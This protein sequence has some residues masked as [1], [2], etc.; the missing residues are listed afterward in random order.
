MVYRSSQFRSLEVPHL[1]E[2]KS[3]FPTDMKP[4]SF[5]LLGIL[6]HFE[7]L[8]VKNQFQI[9]QLPLIYRITKCKTK[10]TPNGTDGHSI[11]IG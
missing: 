2:K 8:N 9:N 5:I 4:F 7:Y 6:Q 10:T 11:N 3:E 1:F